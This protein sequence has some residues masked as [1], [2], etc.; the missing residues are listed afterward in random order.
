[1]G[2]VKPGSLPA[3]GRLFLMKTALDFS[4]IVGEMQWLFRDTGNN[5][6]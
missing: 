4:L 6:H 2:G 3:L 5:D 1:L